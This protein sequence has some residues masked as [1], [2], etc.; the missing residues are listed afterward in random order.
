MKVHVSGQGG[1]FVSACARMCTGSPL[2]IQWM[3]HHWMEDMEH[4]SNYS[5]CIA[6]EKTICVQTKQIPKQQRH[7][8]NPSIV[9]PSGLGIVSIGRVDKLIG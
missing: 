7:Y 4:Y 6:V 9:E 2:V 8:N 5:V 1:F 3:S